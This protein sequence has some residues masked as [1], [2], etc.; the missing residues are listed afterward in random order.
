M[1]DYPLPDRAIK[2]KLSAGQVIPAHPLAL[3]EDGKLDEV[4]Q[5]AL[6]RYYIAA[7]AGGLAVGVHNT[8]FQIHD[9]K[10]GL[11]RPVLELAM[12]AARTSGA[13]MPVMIAGVCGKTEQAVNEAEWA[14]EYG[15]HMGLL[16]LSAMKGLP[17][18]ELIKHCRSVAQVIPLVGFYLQ[19]AVGGMVLDSGFWAELAEIPNLMGV[20]IAPFNRYYTIDVLRAVAGS[21]R[22][23]DIALYTGNDDTII[24][25][26]LTRYELKAG[27]QSVKLNIAGG[28]L[29]QWA[30]WTKRAVETLQR[31]KEV[32]STESVPAELLTLA[33]QLTEANG[34][35]FDVD[36]GFHGCIAGT[37]YVL[38]RVGLVSGPWTL[39][40]NESLSPGQKEKIERI[41]AAYPHL[42]DDDFV[43]EH[44]DEWMY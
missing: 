36:N 22:K 23:D 34:A 32:R 30:C 38:S 40:P 37:S 5:R 35:I 11:Y 41:I 12:D 17:N 13:D 21:S 10:V 2:E 15:Y 1:A 20:K 26:L 28:L 31:I 33:V 4:R 42:T 25:D 16:S 19:P 24:A 18:D 29:G 39:D 14:V 8:Q 43:R 9:P 3:T 44:L 27:G 6:T 7:G